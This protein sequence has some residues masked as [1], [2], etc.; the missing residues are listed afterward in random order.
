VNAAHASNS[1]AEIWLIRMQFVVLYWHRRAFD[2]GRSPLPGPMQDVP[3]RVFAPRSATRSFREIAD[4]V[5]MSLDLRSVPLN[6]DEGGG[7]SMA[8]TK[9]EREALVSRLKKP[10]VF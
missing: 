8:L 1:P 9:A 10:Q 6:T 2:N 4:W 5:F 7:G 3:A